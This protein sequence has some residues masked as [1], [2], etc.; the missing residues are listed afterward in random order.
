MI[1]L[2]S[3]PHFDGHH[4]YP[5]IHK[6]PSN[7]GKIGFPGYMVSLITIGE[8]NIDIRKSGFNSGEPLSRVIPGSI[9]RSKSSQIFALSR[10]RA[11]SSPSNPGMR[12]LPAMCTIC[13][14]LKNYLLYLFSQTPI[15]PWIVKESSL[16]LAIH[17]YHGG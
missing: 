15:G 3:S 10:T 2:P 14:P 13:E 17:Y 4:F 1:K 16:P 12:K 11:V 9:Q 8:K 7:I 5:V 6:K